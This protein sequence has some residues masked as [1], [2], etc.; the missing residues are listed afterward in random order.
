M[1]SIITLKYQD[2]VGSSKLNQAWRCACEFVCGIKGRMWKGRR[3]N[4]VRR[5]R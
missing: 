2:G 1:V 4:G 5:E 3:R